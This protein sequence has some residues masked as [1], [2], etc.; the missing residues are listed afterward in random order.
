MTTLLEVRG[1]ELRYLLTTY[2]FDHG[3]ASVDELVDALAYQ[4]FAVKGRPSNAVSERSSASTVAPEFADQLRSPTVA[5][6]GQGQRRMAVT[7]ATFASPAE[8]VR[9][10]V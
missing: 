10:Q 7:S 3:P 9:V 1:V 4:G 8:V 6:A 5:A 2:L